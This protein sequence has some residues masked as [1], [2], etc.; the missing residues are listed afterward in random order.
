MINDI[1]TYTHSTVFASTNDTGGGVGKDWTLGTSSQQGTQMESIL[2]TAALAQTD[3]TLV[4]SNTPF[5][6]TDNPSRY[7]ISWGDIEHI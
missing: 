3:V 1:A 4:Y 7:A 5:S 6:W 2:D